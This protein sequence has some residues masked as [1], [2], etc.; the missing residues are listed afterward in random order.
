MRLS[1]VALAAVLVVSLFPAVA[2]ARDA[3]L[4]VVE[5]FHAALLDTM[6][7]GK[8]LGINGR[9]K[10]LEPEVGADFDLATMT[11]FTVGPAW[12]SMTAADRASIIA[13]FKRMTVASYARNFA[14]FKDQVFTLDEK[15]EVRGPDR[16]VKSQIIPKGEKPVN[17][18]YRLRAATGSVKVIDVIYQS[19][20]QVATRRSDFASTIAS[21]GAQALVDKLNEISDREMAGN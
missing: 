19:V 11:Q 10:K 12:S 16:L 7:Q 5:R 3:N 18:V 20:S 4:M 8:A 21:G 6:K 15:V 14:E 9:F 1:L 17:L 13:A 2:S